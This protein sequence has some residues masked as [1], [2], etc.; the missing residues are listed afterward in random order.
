ML[1]DNFGRQINY[2]RISVTDRCDFRCVYC[3]A[4]EMTFLPR[5]QLL[6]F[7]ELESIAQAFV[8]LGVNKIRITGGEP[9][10]RKDITTLI[11][12]L[13]S[14]ERL[15][16]LT[17]T[18]NGSHLKHYAKDLVSAGIKR[19]NISLDSL[20]AKRFAKITRTGKLQDVLSGIEAALDAGLNIKL[21]SVILKNRNSDEVLDLVNFAIQKHIDIS[22]IEEMPLGTITSHQRG[23]EFISSESL[24]EI[25]QQK[26]LLIAN[27]NSLTNS[28]PSRY[29]QIVN[30]TSR[31][32]F[33]S[34]HSENFCTTC[35]RVRLTATGRLLLCLG[36]EHSIDLKAV[37]RQHPGDQ[38][39]LKQAIKDSLF[40][41]PKKHD[42]SLTEPVQILRF[43]N[44]TGG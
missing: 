16:E 26:H 14:I 17:L 21:N 35:N 43:M 34:P 19:I 37:I 1:I 6:N 22:F 39:R 27:Q 41:K 2:L 31:I 8:K 3:M 20:Q 7:E 15:K 18:T 33:I 36:N 38:E 29:W 40:I 13:S 9:L 25:I 12:R 4:E 23:Q 44:A 32:G 24:R 28:G 30:S 42:F 10:I 11:N 5:N